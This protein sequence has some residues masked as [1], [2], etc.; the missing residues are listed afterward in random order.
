MFGGLGLEY[1]NRMVCFAQ[2]NL[3]WVAR[4]LEISLSLSLSSTVLEEALEVCYI[5][6]VKN[7]LEE[8]WILVTRTHLS[9]Q[10]PAVPG[11]GACLLSK[12][13]S[14]ALLSRCKVNVAASTDNFSSLKKTTNM[15][16]H[17]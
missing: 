5:G 9:S 16:E 8:P 14:S 3:A 7:T 6:V 10:M 2:V 11:C 4:A 12:P 15:I 17:K 1:P 13:K